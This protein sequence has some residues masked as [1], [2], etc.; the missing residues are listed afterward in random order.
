SVRRGAGAT[1]REIRADRCPHDVTGR[2]GARVVRAVETVR[3][4]EQLIRVRLVHDE[5]D[6]EVGAITCVDP[7]ADGPVVEEEGAAI[8]HAVWRHAEVGAVHEARWSETGGAG[9]ARRVERRI[10]QDLATVA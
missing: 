7:P 6:V 8:V 9:G 3:P 10:D 4:Q 2:G 5:W 1:A